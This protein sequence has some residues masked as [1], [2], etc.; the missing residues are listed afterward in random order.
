MKNLILF[1]LLLIA[2]VSFGQNG[3]PLT[4]TPGGTIALGIGLPSSDIIYATGYTQSPNQYKDLTNEQK[5]ILLTDEDEYDTSYFALYLN[6]QSSH[7]TDDLLKYTKKVAKYGQ[8]NNMT[9]YISIQSGK[10]GNG[11][12]PGG[13]N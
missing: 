13:C 8:K 3:T 9:V 12:P 2:G 4:F 10:P 6:I 11:C 7:I 1:A 5:R